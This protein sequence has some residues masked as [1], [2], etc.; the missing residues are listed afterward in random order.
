MTCYMFPQTEIIYFLLVGGH[1]QVTTSR[2]DLKYTY[3]PKM[4]LVLQVHAL[5][6]QI[7]I[8]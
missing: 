1:M 2:R 8:K 3:S 7:Y 6:P 5:L 4:G